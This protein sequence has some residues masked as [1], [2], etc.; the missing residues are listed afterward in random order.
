MQFQFNTQFQFKKGFLKNNQASIM[1]VDR[2]SKN[3]D[4][5]KPCAGSMT[6]SLYG[7]NIK[8][9]GI[10]TPQKIVAISRR[11]TDPASRRHARRRAA[12]QA[13]GGLGDGD[14]SFRRPPACGTPLVPVCRKSC[15]E[16]KISGVVPS[17]GLTT[18]AA[19]AH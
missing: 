13:G 1:Q 19:P 17:L 5:R 8:L 14:R 10:I 18:E 3:L 7:S 12:L 4:S 16:N 2:S 11:W 9:C 15:A 6:S